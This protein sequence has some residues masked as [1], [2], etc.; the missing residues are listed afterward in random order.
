MSNEAFSGTPIFN[1]S[2][3]KLLKC[4][5][6][7]VMQY[8]N[9]RL[10]VSLWAAALRKWEFSKIDILVRFCYSLVIILQCFYW[11]LVCN[12]YLAGNFS[13][14]S[15]A[16]YF[17]EHLKGCFQNFILCVIFVRFARLAD[18]LQNTQCRINIAEFFFNGCNL[19]L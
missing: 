11:I 4:L 19:F 18:K 17:Y 14:F 2:V 8:V 15:R 6:I 13:N 10:E 16:C 5:I 3:K 12:K 1:I 9:S 7:E